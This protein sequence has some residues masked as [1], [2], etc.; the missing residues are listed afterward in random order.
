MGIIL[1]PSIVELREDDLTMLGLD[2]LEESQWKKSKN[3]DYWIRVDPARP[4]L[5]QR[6][7][8]H[9][10]HKKHLSAK[11][12]QVVW[13]DDLTRHDKKTFDVAFKGMS[14]AK[15]IAKSALGLPTDAV[16]EN[17]SPLSRLEFLVE[18]VLD[19]GADA[20]P[21]ITDTLCFRLES[22]V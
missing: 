12:K 19:E 17:M 3:P 11:N 21:S 14:V 6:R 22:P 8:V 10:A 5:K 15:D 20:T 9:I 4:E 18:E 13:N 1:P 2:R 16:L 7:H